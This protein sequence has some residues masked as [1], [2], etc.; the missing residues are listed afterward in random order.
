MCLKKLQMFFVF[1][2]ENV[3]ITMNRSL[4]TILQLKNVVGVKTLNMKTF[5]FKEKN[6]NA[7]RVLS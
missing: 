1:W 2:L 6:Y 4:G 3:I 5:F 7:F